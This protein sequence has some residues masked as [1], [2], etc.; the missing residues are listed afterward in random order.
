MSLDNLLVGAMKKEYLID[1]GGTPD[2]VL[3]QDKASIAY[4]IGLK[5][6][7][8]V[9]ILDPMN[10]ARAGRSLSLGNFTVNKIKF[11]IDEVDD[12][13]F[14]AELAP[15]PDSNY[16][17]QKFADVKSKVIGNIFDKYT[18]RIKNNIKV[19]E[20]RYNEISSK[21]TFLAKESPNMREFM[22]SIVAYLFSPIKVIKLEDIFAKNPE[23]TYALIEKFSV[24]VRAVCPL[25]NLF[26]KNTLGEELACC[27]VAPEKIIKGG[28]FIPEEGFFPILTYLNGYRM[29]L[30]DN[31]EYLEKV[32]ELLSKAK[33]LKETNPFVTYP[34]SEPRVAKFES[35]LI[36]G[37][38][39][40]EKP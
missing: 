9:L 8:L 29:F 17:K 6:E 1:I 14:S 3:S 30:R 33:L 26:I 18:W 39:K 21:I 22:N 28:T 25:C 7:Q 12:Q 36:E 24:P 37:L 32:P 13:D 4:K 23:N 10:Q 5:P 40:A 11:P 35:K 20:K 31:H 15:S 27:G 38:L 16:I 2:N 19:V 34:S